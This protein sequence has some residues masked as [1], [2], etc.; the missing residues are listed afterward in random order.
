MKKAI[1]PGSFDPITN[2]HID[3]IKRAQKI[4]DE[5]HISVI[6]NPAKKALFS[7]SERIELIKTVFK[8]EEN[9]F[10]EGFQGLLVD[11]AKRK[12]IYTIIRGLRVVSDFDYEFQLAL[13]NRSLNPDLDTVLLMTD[14][15]Y[16]YLSSSVVKQL[17]PHKDDLTEFVP[18]SVLKA[19]KEKLKNE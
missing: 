3:I 2:G 1:Y 14:A 16:S 13:T 15:K 5:V 6:N 9:I 12:K 8:K 4:F 7:I 10:V 19:L 18:C 11:L 17:A